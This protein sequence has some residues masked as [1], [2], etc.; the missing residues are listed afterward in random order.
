MGPRQRQGRRCRRQCGRDAAGRRLA[1]GVLEDDMHY[2]RALVDA[3]LLDISGSDVTFPHHVIDHLC[4]HL[5]FAGG[6]QQVEIAVCKQDRQRRSRAGTDFTCGR[7]RC[8]GVR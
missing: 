2:D 7:G 1:D 5:Y 8:W 4:L 6:G 3:H